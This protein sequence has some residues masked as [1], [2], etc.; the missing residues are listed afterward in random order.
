MNGFFTDQ[1]GRSIGLDNVV[2]IIEGMEYKKNIG[3][4]KQKNEA[5]DDIFDEFIENNL[6]ES[7]NLNEYYR[8][9]LLKL[10]YEIS[11]DFDIDNS[12][13]KLLNKYLYRF[14]KENPYGKS[15]LNFKAFTLSGPSI[16]IISN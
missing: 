12:N 3:F 11:F 16:R 13:R 15:S 5:N 6:E 9:A 14:T 10:N 1:K 4:E 7:N 8:K 2:V